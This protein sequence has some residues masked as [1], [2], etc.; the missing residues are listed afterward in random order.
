MESSIWS[1]TFANKQLV[2]SGSF[3]ETFRCQ[4]I[5]RS[6]PRADEYGQW[7]A[8]KRSLRPFR[9]KKD[10]GV[11]L[12][13][14]ALMELL[15]SPA[16]VGSDGEPMI[17]PH[18]HIVRHIRAWQEDMHFFVQMEFCPMNLTQYIAALHAEAA[19]AAA[20]TYVP[21]SPSV[22]AAT[23]LSAVTFGPPSSAPASATSPSD[24]SRSRSG[25]NTMLSDALL[26]NIMWQLASALAHV[27]SR[28]L[29]HLD[30]KPDN[31]LI[32]FSGMLRLADFG[33]ARLLRPP[34]PAAG[35]AAGAS[36]PLISASASAHLALCPD[37]DMDGVE[38][39]C[40][41]MAPELLSGSFSSPSSGASS[42][43]ARGGASFAADIFS[44]GLLLVELA[45]GVVL[46]HNG[47]LWHDLRKER[48][49]AVHIHGRVSP[50]MEHVILNLLEPMP[51]K[52]P[53]ARQICEWVQAH[54]E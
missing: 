54:P 31:V 23:L 49:A 10:R 33:Q 1:T 35:S 52:R 30:I 18:E 40:V 46:P 44:L 25:S 39:D 41:Y 22:S 20:G 28:G 14:I 53:T 27:H 50:M 8:V 15:G 38:G 19:A 37:F 42:P 2:G 11:Y 16:G 29:V 32:S 51:H 47:P 9:G 45:S 36:S 21:A 3:F 7:F 26:K 34:P 24:S 17:G 13:E 43:R 6:G 48:G 12:R 4:S 5:S